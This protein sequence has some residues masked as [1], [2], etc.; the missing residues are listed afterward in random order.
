MIYSLIKWNLPAKN[1]IVKKT[2]LFL[3]LK[4]REMFLLDL[5]LKTKEEQDLLQSSLE[6]RERIRTRK[7]PWLKETINIKI[8]FQIWEVRVAITNLALRVPETIFKINYKF[9]SSYPNSNL[10]TP[11]EIPHPKMREFKV[12]ENLISALT[13]VKVEEYKVD[14]NNILKIIDK[15]QIRKEKLPNKVKSRPIQDKKNKELPT[16]SQLKVQKRNLENSSALQPPRQTKLRKYSQ[17][18]N[19]R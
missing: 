5:L 8:N 7:L 12:T 14:G 16:K 1:Q 3:N 19:R 15:T 18:P 17:S 2:I 13:N 4:L 11:L 6:M 10:I 9:K